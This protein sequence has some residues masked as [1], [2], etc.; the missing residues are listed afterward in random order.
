MVTSPDLN[1]QGI[2]EDIK[3]EIITT[4]IES[5]LDLADT[6][7]YCYI[8]LKVFRLFCYTK[9]TL[10]QLPFFNPYAWPL[11]P[12]RVVTQPYF[13]FWGMILPP[14]KIGKGSYDISIILGLEVIA[15][16]LYLFS[17]FRLNVLTEVE[18]YINYLNSL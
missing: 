18:M 2:S 15:T 7:A 8:L 5:L 16:M 11:S 3:I 10:D 4:R 9:I 13:N 14:L 1:F 12:I 17:T 6:L